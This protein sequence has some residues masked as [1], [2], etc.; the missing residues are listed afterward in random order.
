MSCFLFLRN[1]DDGQSL[2][3]SNY[4]IKKCL[5][6]Q[7]QQA[8]TQRLELRTVQIC[9]LFYKRFEVF[10]AVNI[11]DAVFWAIMSC[12][13]CKNFVTLMEAICSSQT[14]V[15]TRTTQRNFPEDG[16]LLVNF[17]SIL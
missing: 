8:S 14:S 17:L 16:I 5:A 4:V 11:R 15:L 7:H 6:L 2:E 9:I 10:T 12:G 13:A 3:P 1:S